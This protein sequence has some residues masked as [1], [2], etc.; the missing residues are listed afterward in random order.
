MAQL[1]LKLVSGTAGTQNSVWFYEQGGTIGRSATCDWSLPDHDRFI[2]NK[3]ASI[4]YQ[5]NQFYLTDTSTNGVFVNDTANLLG[6]DNQVKMAEG[7]VFIIGEYKLQVA[8]IEASVPAQTSQPNEE[9]GGLLDLVLGSNANSSVSQSKD[10]IALMNQEDHPKQDNSLG[11][12]ELLSSP[13]VPSNESANFQPPNLSFDDA[14]AQDEQP[15]STPASSHVNQG[16]PEDWELSGIVPAI[17]N[18]DAS[19]PIP[20]QSNKI[21]EQNNLNASPEIRPPN[22]N[23]SATDN[24]VQEQVNISAPQELNASIENRSA[25]PVAANKNTGQSDSFFTL[26]YQQLGLPNEY[27][28]TVDQAKF[29]EDIAT[30][31]L[32]S[33]KG[34]MALLNGRSIFKQESR[35]SLTSIQPRSNNPL[36][37]SIDP[38]DSLEMLLIKKKA[39]Y[40]SAE[41][42]Y[43]EA[44]SDL[45]SHQMAFLAGLQATLTGILEQ[46]SSDV[47]EQEQQKK[48]GGFMGLNV[49]AQKLNIIENKQKEL[50]DS[51]Q[52]NLNEILSKYFAEAYQ[53]QI[54]NIKKD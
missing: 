44:I 26:L 43:E 2:S 29:A 25:Q 18:A 24:T 20:V 6:R 41:Q 49:K 8:T 34:L 9:S 5:N 33:T 38:S 42:A 1:L 53:A 37:F 22:V 3:H 4:S 27:Q 15:A 10:P 46:L 31:L 39:G 32:S 50:A 40:L 11:L 14:F 47:I 51:V 12:G 30:I 54:D 21:E 45:Q 52:H 35:L 13:V 7:D 36:K 48:S 19:S 17:P 16:I 23:S 28:E